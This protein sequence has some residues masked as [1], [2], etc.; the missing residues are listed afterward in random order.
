MNYKKLGRSGLKISEFVLGSMNF[1]WLVD[2]EDSYRILDAAL[3]AGIN[4]IDTA[5]IYSKWGDSS[6]AGKSEEIIGGWVKDRGVRDEIVLATK[7]RGD[8][9]DRPNDVGLSRKHILES[10]KRSLHRLNTDCIDLYWSHWPDYDTPQEETLRAYTKLVDDGII[11]YIG[12]SNHT[13]AELMESLW[14]SDRNGLIRYDAIQPP[15]SLARRRDYEKH[16]Q[17]VVEKY[18]FGVTSYSP[19]GGGFLTG[20]YTEEELPDSKRAETTKT[21]YFKERNFG[22]VE[23]LKDIAKSNDVSVPQLALAWVLTR[24]TITAPIIGVNSIEQLNENLKAL[25]IRISESNLS[26]LN[27]ISDWT[28]MDMLAR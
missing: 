9:S 27:E 20:K 28:E 12:A 14:I 24:E 23:A 6:H 8:M 26:R 3:E 10:V 21:R 17:P 19:L 15:Y 1:G 4:T 5:D 18:E 16:L 25:E 22:I 11:H 7:V 2:E 13:A